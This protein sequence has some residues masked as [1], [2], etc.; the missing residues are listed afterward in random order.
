MN[1][2]NIDDIAQDTAKDILTRYAPDCIDRPGLR[3]AI[4]T[5]AR[6]G[7]ENSIR[8]YLMQHPQHQAE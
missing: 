6:Q 7:I 2:H 8:L 4:A 5:L 3:A 1:E